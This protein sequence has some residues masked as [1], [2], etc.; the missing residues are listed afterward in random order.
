MRCFREVSVCVFP[1]K[2]SL[3]YG[4]ITICPAQIRGRFVSGCGRMSIGLVNI[5]QR[6]IVLLVTTTWLGAAP[7]QILE[8]G[9]CDTCT[10][11]L[12]SGLEIL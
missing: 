8:R 10:Y 11:G 9:M 12:R 5:R 2:I 1:F 7:G 6:G 3:P 4:T